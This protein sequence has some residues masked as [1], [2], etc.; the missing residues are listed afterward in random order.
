ME[1]V[2]LD[3]SQR[4]LLRQLASD[5]RMPEGDLLAEAHSAYAAAHLE[6]KGWQ[7]L[8]EAKLAEIW[9]NEDDAVYDRL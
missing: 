5:A 9:D 2:Y 8:Q 7:Q 3:D 1:S 4:Q 6:R